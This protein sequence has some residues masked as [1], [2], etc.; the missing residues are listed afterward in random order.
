MPE[1]EDITSEEEVNTEEVV[2]ET[3]APED[4]PAEAE[5]ADNSL[6]ERAQEYGL[7]QE[8]IDAFGDKAEETLDRLAENFDSKVADLGRTLIEKQMPGE[9]ET[10]TEPPAEPQPE[11]DGS[12]ASKLKAEGYEEVLV[13]AVRALEEKVKAAEAVPQQVNEDAILE[14][15]VSELN[16]F[17]SNPPERFKDVVSGV[18]GDESFTTMKPGSDAEKF[19]LAVVEEMDA[20]AAGYAAQGKE[21]STDKLGEKALAIVARGKM[22]ESVEREVAKQVKRRSAAAIS[23]PGRSRAASS[24]PVDKE[25]ERRMVEEAMTEFGL[26]GKSMAALL[27]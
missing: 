7:S 22:K 4:A 17:F 18:M 20:L 25:S 9:P 14:A 16:D 1:L 24:A 5:E 15:K 10:P 19:V 27:E 11:D 8:D 6:L 3:P 23:P 26:A 2:E 13:E 21:L 12:I